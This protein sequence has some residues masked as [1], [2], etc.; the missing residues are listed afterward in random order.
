LF[1]V[2]CELYLSLHNTIF[3]FSSLCRLKNSGVQNRVYPLFAN[4]S[5]AI[6]AMISVPADSLVLSADLLIV[7]AALLS[8]T[9]F[10]YFCLV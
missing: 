6:F 7:F 1:S 3:V 2:L 9:I 10:F 5:F 4:K 8:Q